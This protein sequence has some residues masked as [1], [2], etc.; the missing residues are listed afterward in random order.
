MRPF[1]PAHVT[2]ARCKVRCCI[3]LFGR[4]FAG[5]CLR[6]ISSEAVEGEGTR[7]IHRAGD[8][9][10]PVGSLQPIAMCFNVAIV[11]GKTVCMCRAAVR[12][13]FG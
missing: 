9:K 6:D 12:G 3:A 10:D 13:R 2:Y 8:L 1:N 7:N 11:R 5:K 4:G